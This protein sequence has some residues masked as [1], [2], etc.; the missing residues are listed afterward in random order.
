MGFWLDYLV[1]MFGLVDMLD[2][3][4]SLVSFRK[5]AMN[6]ILISFLDGFSFETSLKTSFAIS[7]ILNSTG[8]VVESM[9]QF[10]NGELF[11]FPD[12]LLKEI[13]CHTDP[14]FHVVLWVKMLEFEWFLVKF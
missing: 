4:W 9:K 6:I 13:N 3:I 8:L 12:L 10:L 5:S 1:G 2:R 14:S 7:L 11:N